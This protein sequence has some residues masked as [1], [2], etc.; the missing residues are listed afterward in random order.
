M[1]PPDHVVCDRPEC[2]RFKSGQKEPGTV[3][4]QGL[5][6]QSLQQLHPIFQKGKMRLTDRD[7]VANVT[8]LTNGWA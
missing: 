3:T 2:A 4:Q 7:N 5:P 8:L 1:V 6:T